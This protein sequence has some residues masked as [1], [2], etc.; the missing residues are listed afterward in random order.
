MCI[1][2]S[3]NCINIGSYGMICVHCGCCEEMNPNLKDRTEKQI[4]YY[5]ERLQEEYNFSDYSKNE[6]IALIQKE[7][8]EEHIIYYKKKIMELEHFL[9]S[10][11]AGE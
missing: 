3:K 4:K 2:A 6:K 11:K 7:N 1:S 5:K 10:L 8:V 9:E